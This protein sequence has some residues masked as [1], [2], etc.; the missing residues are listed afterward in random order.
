MIV[1]PFALLGVTRAVIAR[2]RIFWLRS[3]QFHTAFRAA[4]RLVLSDFRVHGAGVDPA[5]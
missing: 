4:T 5:G 1:L 3:L 2:L